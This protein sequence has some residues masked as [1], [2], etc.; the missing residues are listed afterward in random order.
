MNLTTKVDI[1]R[2][3]LSSPNEVLGITIRNTKTVRIGA[4]MVAA[5]VIPEESAFRS[6]GRLTRLRHG[7]QM[8]GAQKQ[9]QAV[10][11]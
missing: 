10:V 7:N 9:E 2:I 11:T 3:N 5:E 1:Q 6:V 8:P 4:Q